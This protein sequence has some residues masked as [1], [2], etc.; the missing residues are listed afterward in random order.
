MS[1]WPILDFESSLPFLLLQTNSE[2][3]EPASSIT[4]LYPPL[5]QAP[6]PPPPQPPPA[7]PLPPL[8]SPVRWPGP[9]PSPTRSSSSSSLKSGLLEEVGHVSQ[10]HAPNAGRSSRQFCPI[11]RP[12]TQLSQA[13]TGSPSP[14]G[15]SARSVPFPRAGTTCGATHSTTTAASATQ[16]SSTETT[17]LAQPGSP[18]LCLRP[19]SQAR[20][21]SASSTMSLRPTPKANQRLPPPQVEKQRSPARSSSSVPPMVL[22]PRWGMTALFLKGKLRVSRAHVRRSHLRTFHRR[23]SLWLRPNRPKLEGPSQ[24]LP[25]LPRAWQVPEPRRKLMRRFVKNERPRADVTWLLGS[26]PEQ[27]QPGISV[28]L[29]RRR[30]HFLGLEQS[31]VFKRPIWTW[32]LE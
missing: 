20:Q 23:M 9:S 22:P 1:G 13:S 21:R 19:G 31:R 11:C 2:T 24:E 32:V 25:G 12:T 14:M 28:S 3:L 15:T 30:A 10:S 4:W 18:P 16:V 26:M 29:P 17:R 6:S 5:P 8:P 7:V 27:G